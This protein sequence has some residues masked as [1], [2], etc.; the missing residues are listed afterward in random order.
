MNKYNSGIE[1]TTKGDFVQA[2]EVFRNC[3]Q[4]VTLLVVRNQ[5]ELKETQEFIK[6]VTEYIMAMRIELERKKIVGSVRFQLISFLI[7]FNN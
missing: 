3:I 4:S 2:L 5:K 6:K 1:L 7:G